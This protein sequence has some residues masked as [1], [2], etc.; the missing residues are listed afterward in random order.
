MDIYEAF[1]KR[2][3]IRIFK[4]GVTEEQLRKIILAGSKAPSAGNRQSWEF[5]VIDDPKTIDQLGEIKYQLNRK[6]SPGPGETQRDVEDRA[7]NQKKWFQN[8]SVVAVCTRSGD[9]GTGWL[10]VGNMSLAATAAGLGS[11]IISYWDEGKKEVEKI[12]GL[13]LDYELTC[14]MKF[15]VPEGEVAL[16]KKR[17]EFS[18]LHKNKF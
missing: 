18:W 15:G 4:K 10:A 9:F 8:A 6:F 3:T 14:V 1:E 2:R 7:L 5:I 13:P 16:P 12:L 17:P 11:N